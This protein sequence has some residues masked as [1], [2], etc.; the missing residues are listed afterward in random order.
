M[1]PKINQ[2]SDFKSFA[3]DHPALLVSV[4]AILTTLSLYAYFLGVLDR[5]GLDPSLFPLSIENAYQ[6]GIGFLVRTDRLVLL[7]ILFTASLAMLAITALIIVA[8]IYLTDKLQQLITKKFPKFGEQTPLTSI[9]QSATVGMFTILMVFI[10]LGMFYHLGGY[11]SINRKTVD[12]S[13]TIKTKGKDGTLYENAAL[14]ICGQ[15]CAIHIKD[16]DD[17]NQKPAIVMIP[18]SDIEY[19]KQHLPSK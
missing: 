8:V 4:I 13:T 6:I 1:E 2:A 17:L 16:K 18:V 9:S 12:Y 3:K 7:I 19:I 5:F 10:V 14:I 11:K 15:F